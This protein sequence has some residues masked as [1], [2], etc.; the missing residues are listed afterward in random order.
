ME[1]FRLKSQPDACPPAVDGK[2]AITVATIPKLERTLLL[3]QSPK[4]AVAPTSVVTTVTR[5]VED[6]V[7][8]LRKG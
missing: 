5:S 7:A 2:N 1:L 6:T 4:P 3:A 8:I